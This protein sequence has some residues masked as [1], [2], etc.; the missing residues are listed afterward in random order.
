VYKDS[1]FAAQ[2]RR[3]ELLRSLSPLPRRLLEL[4]SNRVARIWAGAAGLVGFVAL[5]FS[6]LLGSRFAGFFLLGTWAAMGLVYL[7]VGAV[8]RRRLGIL[9]RQMRSIGDDPM[10]DVAR[11]ER[12]GPV[13]HV[14][15]A[16]HRL[17]AASF[18]LP[19]IAYTLLTPLFAHLLIGSALLGVSVHSFNAWVLISLLLVGHA[20]V[21]LLILCIM[22]V[23]RVRSELDRGVAVQGATRGFWA[24]LWTVAASSIPG[25]VLLC[26]PPMLVA[27]TGLLF[28][29]WMFHWASRRAQRERAI[30]EAQGLLALDGVSA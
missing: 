25:A 30:L 27:L 28:V 2:C 23:L 4:H 20:H 24:L 17:E 21:T 13:E 14:L 5:I 15:R 6:V 12:G 18:M 8:M 19:L 16:T 11:L 22:H 3:E 1:S 29:P 10:A 7:V 26:I 9:S